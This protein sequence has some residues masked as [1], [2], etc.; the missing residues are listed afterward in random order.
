MADG[1]EHKS[2]PIFTVD[3][4]ASAPFTGNS[5]AVCP[6]SSAKEV[7]REVEASSA[8]PGARRDCRSRVAECC[9]PLWASRQFRILIRLS[10]SI[11]T[12]PIHWEMELEDGSRV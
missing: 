7:N 12:T 1:N 2:L 5:A 9:L 11:M 8:R 4:F 6:I 10:Q 3:A